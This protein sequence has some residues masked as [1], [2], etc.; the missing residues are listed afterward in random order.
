MKPGKTWIVCQRHGMVPDRKGPFFE[1]K[2][3]EEFIRELYNLYP[4]CICTV[5]DTGPSEGDIWPTHG[6]EWLDMYGDK[7]KRHPRK[8]ESANKPVGYLR[9]SDLD[10]LKTGSA[11]LYRRRDWQANIPVYAYPSPETRALG[12]N[13]E[14]VER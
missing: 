2:R 14:R 13:T 12:P 11:H 3:I 9:P 8:V 6:Y 7:R 1:T 5:I 4:G 10:L